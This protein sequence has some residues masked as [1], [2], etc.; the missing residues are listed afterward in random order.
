MLRRRTF[1]QGAANLSV[2]AELQSVRGVLEAQVQAT[3]R[4]VD[5]HARDQQELLAN[6]RQLQRLTDENEDLRR[7]LAAA[8]AT[9]APRNVQ[10]H[11]LDQQSPGSGCSAYTPQP[12]PLPPGGPARDE[13]KKLRSQLEAEVKK[14]EARDQHV[15]QLKAMYDKALEKLAALTAVGCAAGGCAAEQHGHQHATTPEAVEIEQLRTGLAD[16]YRALALRTLHLD[17]L[18][19]AAVLQGKPC[20]HGGPSA[21]RHLHAEPD[22]LAMAIARQLIKVPPPSQPPQH[23]PPL[24]Q[25]RVPVALPPA[26]PMD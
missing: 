5:A 20:P 19:C 24:Q 13:S 4:L 6:A 7:R 2:V 16:T 3:A 25:A 26:G 8:E 12:P 17:R 1:C 21:C 14:V 22:M 15:A 11:R 9:D 10:Q 18:H 23:L